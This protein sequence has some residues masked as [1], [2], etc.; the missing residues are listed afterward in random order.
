[1]KKLILLL[2]TL[3]CPYAMGGSLTVLQTLTP[4]RFVLSIVNNLEPELPVPGCIKGARIDLDPRLDLDKNAK[5]NWA[6]ADK[7]VENFRGS[8]VRI[9]ITGFNAA[10]SFVIATECKRRWPW[11][12]LYEGPNEPNN[13]TPARMYVSPKEHVQILR[14]I[15]RAIGKD[16][17]L[18]GGIFSC[19]DGW[20]YEYAEQF[21]KEGGFQVIDVFGIN[22]HVA[23]EPLSQM[24]KMHYLA[25]GF[26]PKVEFTE[27]G[28]TPEWI[29]GVYG[30]FN[31]Y[32]KAKAYLDGVLMARSLDVPITLYQG[33]MTGPQG[34][35]HYLNGEGSGEPT[36]AMKWIDQTLKLLD[37]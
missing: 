13:K 32:T 37:D 35:I 30:E 18:I 34:L 20:D 6:Q 19:W 16:R 7:A 9:Q 8:R 10:Q 1:M 24:F 29:A 15:K 36:L 33:P 21:K 5:V 26:H 17:F 3:L 31:E 2:F 11:I 14:N 27:W 22:P 23:G 25:K 4:Q 12:K 28:M